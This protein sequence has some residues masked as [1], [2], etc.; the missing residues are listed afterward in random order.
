MQTMKKKHGGKHNG[1]ILLKKNSAGTLKSNIL[2]CRPLINL[3]PLLNI[4]LWLAPVI[5]PSTCIGRE[6]T[7]SNTDYLYSTQKKSSSTPPKPH[8]FTTTCSNPQQSKLSAFFSERR[9]IIT[10]LLV[11]LAC[12]IYQKEDTQH[13]SYSQCTLKQSRVT[14]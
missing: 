2:T 13:S 7:C 8:S 9:P 3:E 4:F 12:S 1:G 11:I 6:Q 10:F 14:K 5:R